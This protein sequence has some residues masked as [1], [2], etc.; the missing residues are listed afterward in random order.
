MELTNDL[1]LDIDLTRMMLDTLCTNTYDKIM[2][3]VDRVLDAA[4]VKKFQIDHVVCFKT[5]YYLIT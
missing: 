3:L 2:Q 4:F 1:A 5:L